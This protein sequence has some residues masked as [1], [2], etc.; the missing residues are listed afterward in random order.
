MS[1][2]QYVGLFLILLGV[3]EY[4]VFRYL[5]KTKQNIAQRMTILTLNSL[6]NVVVGVVLVVVGS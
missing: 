1:V 2:L 5:A 4:A 6:L 3:T